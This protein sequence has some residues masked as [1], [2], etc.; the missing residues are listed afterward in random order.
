M[1]NESDTKKEGTTKEGCSENAERFSIGGQAIIEGLMMIGP[2]NAAIAV[3]KPNKEIELQIKPVPTKLK[4]QK[5]PVFRG[6]VGLFRQLKIGLG[7]MM[8]SAEFFD[9]EE[10]GAEAGDAAEE[11]PSKFELFL[12]RK[13]GDKATEVIVTFAVV[14]SLFFSVG[15]F[16][17]L[18]NLLISFFGFDKSVSSQLLLSN[19]CEGLLRVSLFIGYLALTSRLK[20]ISRVWQYHGAEH[21]T[22]HCY[23]KDEELTV[24]NIRKFSTKH[25]RCGT[26]FLFLV[27][28]ISILVF[29]TADL[30]LLQLPFQIVVVAR[31]LFNLL[32]RLLM[33]PFVAGI[34]YE[35]TKAAGKYDNKL[36]RAVSAPGLMFQKFTTREPD[37]SMLEVAIVAFNSA[38]TGLR[39]DGLP[40]GE[41]GGTETAGSADEQQSGAGARTD[42]VGAQTD[43]ITDGGDAGVHTDGIADG[44]GAGEHTDSAGAHAGGTAGDGVS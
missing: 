22:I 4:I 12:E 13:L 35:V 23:E 5:V 21:K 15:L 1:S 36:T 37:D 19:L 14:L 40:G 30:I 38:L 25:P 33:I 26:S 42:G 34:S 6:A 44:G 11:E 24:E 41:S 8:F 39:P 16:I 28:I 9:I 32:T 17:L 20:E 43:G 3:R 18:P 7:A 10:E 29:S 27:M 2:E 31:V